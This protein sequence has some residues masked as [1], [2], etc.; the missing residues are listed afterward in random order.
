MTRRS[1]EL[2]GRGMKKGASMEDG[3]LHDVDL[4]AKVAF[5]RDA[6]NYPE[7]TT[8]VEVRETNMSFVF[9]TNRHAYKMKKPVKR[10]FLDFRHLAARRHFCAEE[11]RLNRRFA[12]SVYLGVVE[13]TRRPPHG[14]DFDGGG[15]VV[16]AL[17]MMRRLSA[18]MTLEAQ[19]EEGRVDRRTLSVFARKM[20]RF[21]RDAPALHPDPRE[22]RK[23]LEGDI[24]ENIG[25]LA[26]SGVAPPP[27]RLRRL[28]EA[29]RIFLSQSWEL[30]ES[31]IRAG[32]FVEGHGDLRPEHVYLLDDPCALDCLEFNPR[33]R[34]LDPADELSFLGLECARLGDDT[35]ASELLELYTRETGDQPPADLLRFYRVFRACVRAKLA[36]WHVE[37]PDGRTPRPW[38]DK[39]ERYL[40]LAERDL[41]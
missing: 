2:F 14:L 40:E 20:A 41:G 17:V 9:L 22:L 4:A 23:H 38:R 25:A 33:F 24:A 8:G 34:I 15:E 12:P 39:A 16:E 35:I 1:G 7:D 28:G 3:G 31:R 36:V 13:L 32:R 11:V 29:Q 30:L 18:Q 6:A 27:A 26:A 10:P 37:G 19:L 5:L 21:Y